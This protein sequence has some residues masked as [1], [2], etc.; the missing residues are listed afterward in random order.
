MNILKLFSIRQVNV[1]L[2][3]RTK[4]EVLEE[5]VEI[6]ARN[7]KIPDPAVLLQGLLKREQHYSTGIGDSVAV[8][9]ARIDNLSEP[10]LF[11]G[12]SPEGIDFNASDGN[13]V[14]VIIL[15]VTPVTHVEIGLK[16][17]ANVARIISRTGFVDK[18]MHATSNEDLYDLLK[19]SVLTA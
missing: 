10:V 12:L 2:L 1:H 18:L 4:E 13:P 11:V 17:L 8:P 15:F 7:G 9:H 19:H 3:S 6:L 5:I 14:H 16:I